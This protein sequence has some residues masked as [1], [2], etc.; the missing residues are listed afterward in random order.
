M[1]ISKEDV[2]KYFADMRSHYAAYHNHKE[3]SAW[4]AV[5]IY[6]V[7]VIQI[8]GT[9]TANANG[10]ERFVGSVAIFLLWA[11]VS[12]YTST[13]F[14]LRKDAAGYVA[15]CQA[16]SVEYLSSE[17]EQIDEVLFR[18]I[19]SPDA[20]HHSPHVLPKIILDKA[21]QLKSVGQTMRHRLENTMYF[22]SA[23][24]LAGVG[25]VIFR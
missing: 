25:I 23:I 1:A 13:Q 5:A 14:R 8:V 3:T 15:A 6:L 2:L 4:A 12:I 18:L 22:L 11:S 10:L 24:G 21:E 9:V 16:L 19:E 17:L 20:G 7:I